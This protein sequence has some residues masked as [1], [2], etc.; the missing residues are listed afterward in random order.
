MKKKCENCTN[1]DAYAPEVE[2]MYS[3][4][5]CYLNEKIVEGSDKCYL[6]GKLK[7]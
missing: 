5:V 2:D 4:G 6:W 1:F 3:K 7:N